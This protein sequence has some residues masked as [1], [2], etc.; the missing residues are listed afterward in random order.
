MTTLT[1]S[2][3]SFQLNIVFSILIYLISSLA[4]IAIVKLLNYR[5]CFRSWLWLALLSR[6]TWIFSVGLHVLLQRKEQINLK[7]SCK[8]LQIYISIAIGLSIVELFNSVSMSVLPGSLYMLIKGSD[9][10]WSMILSYLIL[11]KGYCKGQIL[12]AA[13]IMIGILLVFGLND[14]NDRQERQQVNI[15]SILLP[16]SLCLLGALLNSFCTV[17][18]ESTLKQ[19]LAEEETLMIRLGSSSETAHSITQQ[20]PSKLLLSN[21]YSMWTS[22]FTFV[23]LLVPLS[24][25]WVSGHINFAIPLIN[26]NFSSLSNTTF[27][28]EECAQKTVEFLDQGKNENAKTTTS[29]GHVAIV[30]I[31]IWLGLLGFSRFLERLCKHWICICDSAVTF[32]VV[33]AARRISGIYI[34]GFLFHEAFSIGLW[35]GSICSGIGFILKY[36]F[37]N[38][39]K[40]TTTSTRRPANSTNKMKITKKYKRRLS[41]YDHAEEGNWERHDSA[42]PS[43]QSIEMLSLLSKSNVGL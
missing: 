20:G 7:F 27:S 36:L 43:I 14:D 40:T 26:D 30:S 24:I 17:V 32:S 19:T 35:I 37:R 4:G 10:G 33:Q 9:V 25:K 34:I 28:S 39:D 1:S 6:S 16:S 42:T 18:S 31:G 38:V 23:L 22:F 8:Q 11:N 41:D 13:L 15:S 2:S 5:Y 21:A 12:A 29:Y 3:S